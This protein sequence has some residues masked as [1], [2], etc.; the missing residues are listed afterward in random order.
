MEKI[1]LKVQD[2]FSKKPVLAELLI[3][4]I[5]ALVPLLW[6][7]NSNAVVIGH[8]T[9]FSLDP[10]SWFEERISTWSDNENWGHDNSFA[11]G[12]IFVHLPEYL[13]AKLGFDIYTVERLTF[14]FWSEMLVISMY[15]LTRFLSKGLPKYTV[16]RISTSLLYLFNYYVLQAWFIAERTKFS[17]M[18]ALPLVILFLL[19]AIKQKD[20]LKN[21][22][23]AALSLTIF[24]GGGSAFTLY[25]GLFLA[26][27]V[28]FVSF[29]FVFKIK[30][31]NTLRIFF[32]FGIIFLF[33]NFYWIIPQ[34]LYA[35]NAY[36]QAVNSFGGIDSTIAWARE[37]SK[38]ASI[39]NL[40]RLQGFPD[41]YN[42]PNHPYSNALFNNSLFNILSFLLPIAAFLPVLIYRKK[43]FL[44]KIT[45]FFF[46]LIILGIILTAGTQAPF[47]G[48]YEFLLRYIPFFSSYRTPFF[49]FGYVVWFSYALMIGL[50]LNYLANRKFLSITLDFEGMARK[51]SIS[52]RTIINILSV[53]IIL[54]YVFPYFNNNFFNW[55]KDFSTLVDP[56]QYIFEYQKWSKD[57]LNNGLTLVMPAL[58]SS[59]IDQYTWGYY[60]LQP[61]PTI[62]SSKGILA[63]S[64]ALVSSETEKNLIKIIYNSLENDPT[65]FTKLSQMYNIKSILLRKDIFIKEVNKDKINFESIEKNLNKISSF[66]KTQTWGEWILYENDYPSGQITVLNNPSSVYVDNDLS[67]ESLRNILRNIPENNFIITTNP[68]YAKTYYPLLPQESQIE[69]SAVSYDLSAINFEKE[70]ALEFKRKNILYSSIIAKLRTDG[71]G[72]YELILKEPDINFVDIGENKGRE[73]KFPFKTTEGLKFISINNNIFEVKNFAGNQVI[74]TLGEFSL[75]GESKIDIAYYTNENTTILTAQSFENIDW[76]KRISSCGNP[77][78]G[79]QASY[80]E[81]NGLKYLNISANAGN[82][83]ITYDLKPQYSNSII[84]LDISTKRESGLSPAVC[85]LEKTDKSA[86]CII[87]KNFYDADNNWKNHSLY[88]LIGAKENQLVLHLYGKSSDIKTTSSYDNINISNYSGKSITQNIDITTIFPEQELV[89]FLINQKENLTIS[90]ESAQTAINTNEIFPN[91]SFEQNDWGDG[92]VCGENQNQKTEIA[93]KQNEDKTSGNYSLEVR[94]N[95]GT[96]CYFKKLNQFDNS[97]IYRFN[98]DY[99]NTSGK[100]GEICLLEKTL[101]GSGC[102]YKSDL[103]K[104][105]EWKNISFNFTPK[106]NQTESI[107][108][109][110]SGSK[111]EETINLYD[112]L[113]ITK[114]SYPIDYLDITTDTKESVPAEY[115]PEVQINL[116]FLKVVRLKD[117]PSDIVTLG[118]SYNSNWTMIE[119]DLKNKP[120]LLLKIL[121]SVIN[122]KPNNAFNFVH[123]SWTTENNGGYAILIY[124]Q[125]LVYLM[126][127]V[128][129][130][131][132]LIILSIIIFFKRI[133]KTTEDIGNSVSSQTVMMKTLMKRLD[134]FLVEQ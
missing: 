18:I 20:V 65:L 105:S 10:Q 85:L 132:T 12:S 101:I 76:S 19:R 66:K 114:I 118:Y 32:T 21:T 103:E 78:R 6:F 17:I 31:Q 80:Q 15:A 119:S 86:N 129:S 89:K 16:F 26:L 98:F 107:L 43:P 40:L 106:E 69:N 22:F 120:E 82:A 55:N 28:L 74:Q 84:K 1:R 75:R 58:D 3:I 9:G 11:L 35:K 81:M 88:Q 68:R 125:Q 73:Y 95:S 110:Y 121:F 14:V 57:N 23:L 112:N 91:N 71:N 113:S 133:R 93:V 25:A 131:I 63:N 13:F 47:G 38:N 2:F 42:N 59:G 37:I 122:T 124:K 44:S 50:S 8:D 72:S 60:S 34:I 127:L 92:Y 45:K 70:N 90:I 77:A 128:V 67:E 96:G 87:D 100:A 36:S 7:Q 54:I 56:P 33:L 104:S 49:K 53:I 39:G 30:L 4:V 130:I 115:L 27:C 48:I 83:C 94:S 24:N 97:S 52:W 41:W 46:I 108:H 79:A 62:L 5:L 61:L 109:F 111:G 99:K 126:C 123:N 134:N 64:F 116:P 102:E 117:T 51:I 29:I